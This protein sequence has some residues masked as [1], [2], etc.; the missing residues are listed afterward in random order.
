MSVPFKLLLY[1]GAAVFAVQFLYL[2]SLPTGEFLKFVPDDAFYYIKAAQNLIANGSVTFDGSSPTSGV[3][4]LFLLL[5]LPIAALAQ[6]PEAGVRAAMILC[7][8]LFVLS[9]WLSMRILRVLAGSEIAAIAFVAMLTSPCLMLVS[10]AGLETSLALMLL[11]SALFIF[12]KIV[13]E[14]SVKPGPPLLLGILTALAILARTDCIFLVPAFVLGFFF[15]GASGRKML[16]IHPLLQFLIPPFMAAFLLIT[17]CLL[18]TGMP[19]Q[20]SGV[21]L[22]IISRNL[23][24]NGAFSLSSH[25]LASEFWGANSELAGTPP[26]LIFVLFASLVL[27]S[28]FSELSH[29]GRF[30]S[31]A[32]SL[33]PLFIH[34]AFLLLFY[35]VF[36]RHIQLWYIVPVAVATLIVVSLLLGSLAE[37][38]SEIPPRS[39]RRSVSVLTLL[40]GVLILV[41]AVVR[42]PHLMASGIY[43]WQPEMLEAAKAIQKHLPEDAK[44]GAFNAGILGSF[45]D[46]KVINLDGVVNNPLIP[47]LANRNLDEFLLDADLDAIVDYQFSFLKFAAATRYHGYPGY[48]L[49]AELPG[50]WNQTNIWVCRPKQGA[51]LEPTLIRPFSGFYPLEPWS[52]S[53]FEFRWSKGN[54]STIS[55]IPADPGQD[56]VL[57]VLAYPFENCAR[58]GQRVKVRL[59]GRDFGDVN[60]LS[61]W[62]KYELQLPSGSLESG[63]NAIEF[64][65]RYTVCPAEDCDW[66]DKDMRRLAVA[67]REFR[68]QRKNRSIAIE[69]PSS[70]LVGTS[71][72]AAAL[73]SSSAFSTAIP[74]PAFKSRLRSEISSPIATTSSGLIP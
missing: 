25:E 21:A 43:P 62:H 15:C 19:F 50:T 48:E 38:I 44:V 13:A 65:Y 59:N 4:P 31:R 52:D 56:L 49:A 40:V 73:T 68:C 71:R 39:R 9:A 55:L 23:A 53:D 70:L 42:T 16:R 60:L 5:I 26:L 45:L 46:A 58:S 20:S 37:S 6:T 17:W 3:H 69:A 10:V 51:F 63:E 74:T 22:S 18:T 28:L 30:L 54:S 11:L 61:G 47:Y 33:L 1:A 7:A 29:F 2:I 24:E 34:A 27:V 14:K 64:I 35:T 72:S 41:M 8:I 57:E 66:G 32:L 67:F 12:V 36:M